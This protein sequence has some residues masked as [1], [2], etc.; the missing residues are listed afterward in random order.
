MKNL[1]NCEVGDI[2]VATPGDKAMILLKSDKIIIRSAWYQFDAYG[3]TLTIE[4]CKKRDY[5]ILQ[6]GKYPMKKK[7]V[8]ELLNIKIEG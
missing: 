5:R 6:E 7:E 2:L 1:D 3:A 8:E 4:D